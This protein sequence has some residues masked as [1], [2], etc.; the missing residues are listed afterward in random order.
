MVSLI[1]YAFSAITLRFYLS[2]LVF[3]KIPL[4]ET[5]ES[6]SFVVE[7]N[8]AEVVIREYS[9]DNGNR[10][11]VF[12]PGQHGGIARYEKEIFEQASERG[13]TVYAL[14]YPGYEGASG[15]ATFKNVSSVT[16]SAISLIEKDTFCD[17]KSSVFIGCSLGSAIAVDA[18]LTFKPAGLLLDSVSPSLESVVRKKMNSVL[19]LWPAQL[20]PVN[21]LL[22]FDVNL[23]E[24]LERLKDIPVVIMQ[25][26]M[27]QIAR[28]EK[29]QDAI[30]LHA[31][32]E[33]IVLNG[34]SHGD[35]IQKAGERYFIKLCQLA[36]CGT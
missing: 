27:D 3:L 7:D 33:L 1:Y 9:S 14:S 20:L 4:T 26:V 17:I 34:A 19:L 24:A 5:K 6:R 22:E 36:R 28:P 32:V 29:I 15:N 16:R 23:E 13:I 21:S 12:F 30:K 31:N 8:G 35:T 18:A 10:C 2:D 11:A 25:G